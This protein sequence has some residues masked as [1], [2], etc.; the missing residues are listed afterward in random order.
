MEIKFVTR[1]SLFIFLTL[2]SYDSFS[3]S[4]KKLEPIDVFSMEYVSDPRI[5]PDGKKILYVRN[6]KDI[7]TDKNYSNIWMINFDGSNNTPI[8]TG[9]QNDFSPVWSNSGKMF[10]YKSNSDGSL[11]LYLY[12]IFQ[13]HITQSSTQKLTNLQSSIGSVDWSSDDKFLT[14]NSFVEVSKNKFIEMPK[15]PKGA[16]WNKPPIEIDDMNYRN[17]GRGYKKQGN[18]QVFT[19]PVE[20]GTPRQVTF[21]DKDAGSPKWLSNNE[22]LFS[23]NLHENSDLEPNNS[24]IYLFKP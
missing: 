1:V 3:Q 8:T 23:A 2:F 7:M 21:L 24:E 11:Q 17:D 14:F 10:S 22:I 13:T 12:R 5:S 6:F 15:Q 9:N 16:K 20:G 4:S 18:S 19:L